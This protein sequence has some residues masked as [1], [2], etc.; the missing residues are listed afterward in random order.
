MLWSLAD[1]KRAQYLSNGRLINNARISPDGQWVAYDSNENGPSRVYV[2][3][4]PVPGSKNE[5]S[6]PGGGAQPVWNAAG[7]E[8]F[9][10]SEG[11]LTAVA[12]TASGKTLQ[13][14]DARQLFPFPADSAY[15]VAVKTGRFLL[16]VPASQPAPATVLL[17]WR[18]PARK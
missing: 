1:G 12:L 10:V 3:S 11:N 5:V 6:G 15:D 9:M 17:N 4:F 16:S 2:Q 13:V 8:L 7:T 18:P 14:G